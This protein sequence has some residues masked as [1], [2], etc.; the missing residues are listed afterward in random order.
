MKKKFCMAALLITLV[1]S[2]CT[3]PGAGGDEAADQTGQQKEQ[4]NPGEQPE[5]EQGQEPPKE[6]ADPTFGE[7]P[8]DLYPA[9]GGETTTTTTTTV[10]EN[11]PVIENNIDD[12]AHEIVLPFHEESLLMYFSSG[13]GGWATELTLMRDGSFT[14][15]YHDS[16]MGECGDDYPNGT[17]YV[18]EFSGKFGSF[19]KISETTWSMQ[20]ESLNYAPAGTETYINGTRHIT[21][22]PYGL[23]TGS[24]YQFYTKDKKVEELSRVFISWWEG[25]YQLAY[26]QKSGNPIIPKDLVLDCYGIANFTGNYSE[27]TGEE[28]IYGFFSYDY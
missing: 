13:A 19:Q 26:D 11:A 17:F 14:G 1:L 9:V 5:K 15:N 2:G 3:A 27:T 16:E 23:S 6:E 10:T 8:A 21:T 22:D 25:R 7:I 24:L 20:L 28:E 18:C 4:E 12:P